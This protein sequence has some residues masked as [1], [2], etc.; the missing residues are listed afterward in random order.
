MTFI[1]SFVVSF[2]FRLIDSLNFFWFNL[3]DSSSFSDFWHFM[4]LNWGIKWQ[5]QFVCNMQTIL[6]RKWE[7]KKIVEK[8]TGNVSLEEDSTMLSNYFY[9]WISGENVESW[10][11]V[12]RNCTDLIYDLNEMMV[13]KFMNHFLEWIS[14]R[15]HDKRKKSA[16][17]L[18]TWISSVRA[19]LYLKKSMVTTVCCNTGPLVLYYNLMQR[20]CKI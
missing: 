9:K 13:S 11:K 2:H 4:S 8:W 19:N 15:Q 3:S 17:W 20:L 18:D 6:R 14:K 1:C 7:Y 12:K 10:S 5:R 16:Q